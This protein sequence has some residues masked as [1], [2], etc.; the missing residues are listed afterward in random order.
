ALRKQLEAIDG[1]PPSAKATPAELTDQLFD[2]YDR[3]HLAEWN[4]QFQAAAE[5]ERQGGFK[6]A[7]DGYGWVLAHDPNYGRRGDMAHAYAKRGD[8][9]RAAKQTSEALGYYR[10][11]LDLAPTGPD[12]GYAAARVAL[13]DG[14]QALAL[15]HADE[16]LFQRALALDPA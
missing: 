4:A 5:R 6:G 3:L 15:G 7:T 2:Y 1:E 11:A 12:A 9:L 14:E 10:Q 13:L 16:G 8:E